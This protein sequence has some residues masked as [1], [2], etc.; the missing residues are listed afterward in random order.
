[1][2]TL[3]ELEKRIGALED[4]RAIERLQA[5][6]WDTLDAK[7]WDGLLACLVED[8]VFINNT[9]GGR[10]EGREGMLATMRAKI[11]RRR[12]LE[13]SGAPSLDRADGR[14]HGH[15]PLVAAR[16]SVRCSARRRVRGSRPLRQCVREDRRPMVFHRDVTDVPARRGQHQ[17]ALRRLR[18]RVPGF[19]DVRA[20]PAQSRPG[21]GSEQ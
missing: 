1:M 20:G 15:L 12:H 13:P 19:H 3:E 7:D 5:R 9:T 21:E 4:M 18:E 16:R 14:G 10:Y 17:E 11:H 6:Y 8:F 2:A